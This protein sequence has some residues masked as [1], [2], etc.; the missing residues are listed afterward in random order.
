MKNFD[1]QYRLIAGQAG[2]QGFQIGDGSTPLRI[3]F[4]LQKTD[5]KAQNTGDRKSVV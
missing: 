3:A 2:A 1:R 5:K 4:S